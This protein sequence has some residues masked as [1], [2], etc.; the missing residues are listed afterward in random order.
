MGP[1]VYGLNKTWVDGVV[2]DA[3]R[4]CAVG[5]HWCGE[6]RVAHCDEGVTGGNYFSAIGI[7]SPK[8]RLGSK[9]HDGFN[10]L[11]NCHNG[12]ITKGDWPNC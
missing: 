9:G 5:L 2:D 10:H 1:H 11:G 4:R 7:E 8:L 6:L 12:P 3:K